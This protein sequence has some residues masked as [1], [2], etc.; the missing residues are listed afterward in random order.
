MCTKAEWKEAAE[1]RL[2]EN[3]ALKVLLTQIDEVLSNS[4][5]GFQERVYQASD[6]VSVAK[7]IGR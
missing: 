1:R 2:A 3:L 5:M 7:E 4:Q 6:L